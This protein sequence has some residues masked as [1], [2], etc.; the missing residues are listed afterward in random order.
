MS[1]AR[2]SVAVRNYKTLRAK[3]QKEFETEIKS[4]GQINSFSGL[5]LAKIEIANVVL[6]QR[7]IPIGITLPSFVKGMGI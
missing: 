6:E 1:K 7:G 2:L 4:G 3:L 5:E